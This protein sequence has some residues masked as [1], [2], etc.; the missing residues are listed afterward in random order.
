VRITDAGAACIQF[1]ARNDLGALDREQAVVMGSDVTQSDSPERF[2]RAWNR[3]CLGQSYD[4]TEA[5][6]RFF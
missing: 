4:V 2:R 3:Q 6:D 1:S 5:V